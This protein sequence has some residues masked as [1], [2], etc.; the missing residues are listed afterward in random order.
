MKPND[1]RDNIIAKAVR[2]ERDMET[3]DL[4]LVFLITD[5]HYKQKI[6]KN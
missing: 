3:G 1:P 2:V 5:E 4:Y 6:G